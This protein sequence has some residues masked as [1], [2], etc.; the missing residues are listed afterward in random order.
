MYLLFVPTHLDLQYQ[1][2]NLTDIINF[3]FLLANIPLD[4]HEL[5]REISKLS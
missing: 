3:S 5:F 2:T 4:M 1:S